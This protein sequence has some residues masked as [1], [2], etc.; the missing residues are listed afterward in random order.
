MTRPDPA[1]LA[2]VGAPVLYTPDEAA[3]ILDPSGKLT[4]YWL[5]RRARSGEFPHMK[6]GRSIVFSPANLA[7]IAKG[8]NVPA[9]PRPPAAPAPRSRAQ[10]KDADA[11][12]AAPRLRAN[13]SKRKKAAA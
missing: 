4:G 10:G 11:P 7:E 2:A 8:L 12:G 9:R 1:Q 5:L 6:P 3:L 13:T